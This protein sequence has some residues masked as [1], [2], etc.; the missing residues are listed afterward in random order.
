MVCRLEGTFAASSD[1]LA[2]MASQPPANTRDQLSAGPFVSG[3]CHRL[4]RLG[5]RLTGETAV[6]TAASTHAAAAAVARRCR[7][8]PPVA[9]LP[10][11]QLGVLAQCRPTPRCL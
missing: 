11:P 8:R 4:W 7:R 5:Q 1:R 10:A 2:A 9:Q 6:A 3:T